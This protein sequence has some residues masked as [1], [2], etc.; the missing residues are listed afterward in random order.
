MEGCRCALR[1]K[2]RPAGKEGAKAAV[3]TFVT[4]DLAACAK[5]CVRP[6]NH[7][8]WAHSTPA[9]PETPYAGAV[10]AQIWRRIFSRYFHTFR[11]RRH[12]CTSLCRPFFDRE[13][14]RFYF[15]LYSTFETFPGCSYNNMG[16]EELVRIDEGDSRRGKIL[17]ATKH[18]HAGQTILHEKPVILVPESGEMDMLHKYKAFLCSPPDVQAEILSL[19]SPVDGARADLLRVSASHIMPG[20]LG[21][22]VEELVKVTMAFEFNCVGVNPAPRN[23]GGGEPTSL[24]GGLY[25]TACRAAHSCL[26]NCC[27]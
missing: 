8:G 17:V 6:I 20:I 18:L 10:N 15:F 11:S 1:R 4:A 22:Q 27:W 9:N 14:S 13:F 2:Q 3:V 21:D 23:G 19:Y 24:G 26:P 16:V 7:K 12:L 25:H 5:C